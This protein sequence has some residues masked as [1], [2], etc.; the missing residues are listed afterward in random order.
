VR[1]PHQLGNKIKKQKK[2]K[3]QRKE[4]NNILPLKNSIEKAPA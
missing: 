3:R 4:I 2:K 1:P